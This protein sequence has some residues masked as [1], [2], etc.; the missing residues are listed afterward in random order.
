[1]LCIQ[2]LFVEVNLHKYAPCRLRARQI[3][4]KNKNP[5]KHWRFFSPTQLSI[6]WKEKKK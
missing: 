1:V 2:R 5:V 6:H 4:V 3:G